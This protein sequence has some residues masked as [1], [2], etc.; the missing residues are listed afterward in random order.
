L[1]K[2]SVIVLAMCSWALGEI[3]HAAEGPKVIAAGEWSKAVDDN[4]GY[5]L[6][7]R[8]VLCENFAGT[9]HREVAVYVELQD[10]SEARGHGMQLYCEMGKT[11][12]RPE[13]KGGLQCEMR[14]KDK[15]LVGS[16]GYPFGGGV[17]KPEWVRLP[18][19]ATIRLRASPFGLRRDNAMAISPELG[20]LW[21]IK[22]DDPNEYFLSS[23]FTIAPAEDGIEK[24]GGHIWRGVINLPAVRI[25]NKRP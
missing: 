23:T 16:T 12:F 22:D 8:L 3:G 9:D 4:R 19:D 11:D 5:S 24:D 13:Y 1:V 14:D 20:K 7:G 15:K 10:A 25:K 17:P 18:C 2:T 21:V 6:R